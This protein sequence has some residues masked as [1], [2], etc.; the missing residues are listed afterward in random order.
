MPTIDSRHFNHLSSSDLP[1]SCKVH[2]TETP[3]LWYEVERLYLQSS[4]LFLHGLQMQNP[5]RVGKEWSDEYYLMYYRDL[6]KGNPDPLDPLYGLEK[7]EVKEG[8]SDRE[9]V[10]VLHDIHYMERDGQKFIRGKREDRLESV[11][12]NVIPS[13]LMYTEEDVSGVRTP[14]LLVNFNVVSLLN[15]T[16]R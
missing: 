11:K 4:K 8:V 5:S 10:V 13:K 6:C 14:M 1:Y 15:I 7:F 12:L 16:V 2:F 9:I 3:L